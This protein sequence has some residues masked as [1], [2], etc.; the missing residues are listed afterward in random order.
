MPGVFRDICFV[1]IFVISFATYGSTVTHALDNDIRAVANQYITNAGEWLAEKLQYTNQWSSSFTKRELLYNFCQTVIRHGTL[2]TTLAESRTIT[3]DP[4]QSVFLYIVCS[5][6]SSHNGFQPLFFDKENPYVNPERNTLKKNNLI[7]TERTSD[8]AGRVIYQP[9][10]CVPGCE[11]ETMQTCDFSL[12][13]P[14]ILKQINNDITNIGLGISYGVTNTINSEEGNANL[15]N[16]FAVRYL[17]INLCD[18]AWGTCLYPK[19]RQRV[20]RT[21]KNAK[22]LLQKTRIIETKPMI[23]NA[24]TCKNPEDPSTPGHDKRACAFAWN[25]LILQP[26]MDLLFNELYYYQL[27]MAYY[28][29]YLESNVFLGDFSVG[30]INRE[31]MVEKTSEEIRRINKESSTHLQAVFTA[32][33]MMLQI[34][35]NYPIHVWLQ[36][37]YEGAVTLRKDLAKLYQPLHQLHFKLQDIQDASDN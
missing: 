13:L 29:S 23:D 10:W 9:S 12:L 16:K 21:L 34:Y 4:Q 33:R 1:M 15:A 19:T 25:N 17:G 24:Q 30:T 26:V 2:T 27:F 31:S 5:S 7:C 3:Y 28:S 20:I 35:Q 37:Y 11:T 22:K 6:V 18:E 8:D 14:P 32:N 36:A